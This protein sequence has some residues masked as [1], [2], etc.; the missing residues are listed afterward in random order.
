MIST[1]EDGLG[2]RITILRP[3]DQNAP[4][5]FRMILPKGVGPPTRERHPSHREEFEVIRGTLDLGRIDGKRVVLQAGD[6][7]SLAPGKYHLPANAGDGELEF[8][9][10]LTPGLDAASLFAALYD[11]TREYR[12]LSRFT[13]VS[14]VFRHYKRTIAF[15]FPVRAVM[16][17]V[18]ALASFAGIR[19]PSASLLP[20]T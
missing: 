8:E 3:E 10:T 1:H 9:A 2:G 16:C 5:G 18:A 7:Y 15:P 4:M 12:G 17:L 11:A 13:R 19:V 6:R 20:S 14:I